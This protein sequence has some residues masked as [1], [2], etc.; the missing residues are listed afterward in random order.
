LIPG[1]DDWQEYTATDTGILTEHVIT[2]CKREGYRLRVKA[3]IRIAKPRLR[4]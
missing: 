2:I 1:T 4:K 3:A